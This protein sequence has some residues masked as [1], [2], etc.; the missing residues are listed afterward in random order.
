MVEGSWVACRAN[1]PDADGCCA[2][3][4]MRACLRSRAQLLSLYG[5]SES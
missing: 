3:A 5:A 1:Q 2:E 4:A